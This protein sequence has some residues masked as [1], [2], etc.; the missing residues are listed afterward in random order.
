MNEPQFILI[1]GSYFIFFRYYA[2]LNWFKLAKREQKLDK[3][4]PPEKNNDFVDKFTK[5]FDQK[6]KEIPKKLKI[7]DPIILVGRDCPREKIWRMKYLSTYKANRVYDDSFL[8]GYFF[9]KSYKEDLFLKAGA[10]KI[11]S[12]PS[13]EADDCLAILTK[14]IL[15]KYP[16]ATINIITSDMDYLQLASENVKLYDLKFKR[17]T[18]R[19]SSFN[20]AE[21]DLF[22]KILT[23]DKSDNIQGVFKKCGPKTACKYFDDKE[24]F[25]KK[26]EKEEGALER[27]NLN[28]KIID[29]NEIPKELVE[30]FKSSYDIL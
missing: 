19:K 11:F 26:L 16:K 12:Y 9:K 22:V 28:K 29:F 27:Y 23:G 18:E 21:K 13:L 6:I 10:K 3:E 2:I 7:N 4:N 14:N 5:T 8:G 1:D 15:S 20:N 24:L 30:Q 17:L 25:K